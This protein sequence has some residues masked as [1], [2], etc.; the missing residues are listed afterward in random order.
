MAHACV[1]CGRISDEPRCPAHQRKAPRKPDNRRPNSR[2]RGYDAKWEATRAA[3][4]SEH[5]RCACGCGAEATDVHHLDGLGPLGPRGHDPDNLQALSHSCH[6][7]Q[8]ARDRGYWGPQQHAGP[9]FLIICGRSGTGKTTVLDLTAK[10][11]GIPALSIDRSG[12]D[13]P[14]VFDALD[15]VGTAAVECARLPRGLRNRMHTRSAVVVELTASPE[16]R[17]LR[18]RARGED[19]DT[20]DRYLVDDDG[21]GLGW[22]EQVLPDLTVDTDRHQPAEA[23]QLIAERAG[24]HLGIAN[25]R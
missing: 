2:Q 17:R 16:S 4:L 21:Y 3:Y 20:V 22:E 5:P 14:A 12:G 19:E 25:D 24:S 7:R 18:L 10:R 13:W 6:S 11:L 1:E 8:T 23:A 9:P 15:H